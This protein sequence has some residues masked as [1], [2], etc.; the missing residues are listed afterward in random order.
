VPSNG[1]QRLVLRGL[2]KE[3]DFSFSDEQ[4]H[5]DEDLEHCAQQDHSSMGGARAN[6]RLRWQVLK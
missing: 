5:D 4:L 1:R 6:V 3:S 2:L